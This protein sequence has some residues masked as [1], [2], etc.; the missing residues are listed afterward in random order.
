MFIDQ[1]Y[2]VG[3]VLKL[4]S[5]Q[6]SRLRD[7]QHWDLGGAELG[8]LGGENSQLNTSDRSLKREDKT[9]K[10]LLVTTDSTPTK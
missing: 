8:D 4:T 10:P 7:P 6:P 9:F 3:T 1:H 5:P 2:K